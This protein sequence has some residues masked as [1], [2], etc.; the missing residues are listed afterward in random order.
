MSGD[1]ISNGYNLIGDGT[2]SSGFTA[3][4]DQV[5]TSDNPIDPLLGSLENNGGST[6]TLAL[7]PNSPAIDAGNPNFVAP[8]EFD[9]RGSGFPRILDGNGDGVAIVDIGAFEAS[10]PTSVPESSPILGLSVIVIF[11]VGSF[12]KRQFFQA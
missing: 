11:G 12:L 4:G 7:L 6:L 3:L 10:Q 2:G 1:F 5:G 9:Q 8:P